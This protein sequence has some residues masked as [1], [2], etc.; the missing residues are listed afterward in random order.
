MIADITATAAQTRWESVKAN[1][2]SI[3]KQENVLTHV[4]NT[5]Q[6]ANAQGI[7]HVKIF[8]THMIA[9]ST[10]TA[11]QTRWE[12]VKANS[13]STRKQEN[14]LTHVKSTFQDANAKGIKHVKIFQSHM[15]ANSTVTAAQTGWESVKANSNSTRKQENVLTHAKS[16]SKAVL[17]TI[18]LARLQL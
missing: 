1:S 15:I 4:K 14:V 12:S 11:A 16:T 7:K 13:N 9:K 2:N 18:P 17:A 10:V 8:Q 6:D 3:R 5:S